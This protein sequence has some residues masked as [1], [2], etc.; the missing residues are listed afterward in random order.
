MTDKRTPLYHGQVVDLGMEAA[1]LPDGQT[2]NLEIVRHPGGAAVAALDQ[3]GRLCLLRHYRHAAAGWLW[4]LPAGKLEPGEDPLA[5]AQRELE[6]EAG[7]RAA[8]WR[9]LGITFTTPGFCDEVIHIY[10]AQ[11]LTAVPPRPERH[12]LLESHWVD[13]ARAQAWIRDGT[14]TDAKSIVGIHLATCP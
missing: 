14:L 4:E 8:A 10:L 11:D 12:E 5:A 7:L 9:K 3:Q 2:C 6:E 1:T 13:L